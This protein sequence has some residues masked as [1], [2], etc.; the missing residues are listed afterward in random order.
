[1]ILVELCAVQGVLVVVERSISVARWPEVASRAWT[2]TLM[3]TT[4]PC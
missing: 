2:A 3:V 4:S 1:M